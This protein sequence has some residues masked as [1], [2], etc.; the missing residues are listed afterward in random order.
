MLL[1]SLICYLTYGLWIYRCSIFMICLPTCRDQN[2]LVL[3]AM[4]SRYRAVY[5]YTKPINHGQHVGWSINTMKIQ[6][7][8]L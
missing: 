3:V 7:Q 2:M 8:R 4:P 5:V 1:N 6:R